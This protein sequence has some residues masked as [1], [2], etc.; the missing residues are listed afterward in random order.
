MSDNN[1]YAQ[2]EM[3][4]KKSSTWADIINNVYNR[5][6]EEENKKNSSDENPLIRQNSILETLEKENDYFPGLPIS[7]RLLSTEPK[8]TPKMKKLLINH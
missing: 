8:I 5:E 7:E 4:W 2:Y 3:E 6:E 1:E